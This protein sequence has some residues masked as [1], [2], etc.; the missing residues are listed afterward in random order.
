MGFADALIMMN[1]RY[2]SDQAS[3]FAKRLMMNIRETAHMTSRDLGKE[4]GYGELVR[5]KRRNASLTTIA[6]T[7]TL[8]ILADCSSGIEPLFAKNFTKTVM[9]N[10]KLD[11]G[12]K[13]QNADESI[14]ITAHEISVEKHIEIQSAFQSYTDNAVS[15]TLNLSNSATIED[16]KKA[17][18]LSYQAGC[19][20]VTIFRDGSRAAPLQD[21]D[22][23]SE[24]E[25]NKCQI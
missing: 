15:K 7:G 5:L 20:G 4:K 8:S 16:V 9:D 22:A 18:L 25:G 3:K 1:M 12:K 2:D 13:Y 24:C 17:F 10:V 23:L 19:K 14:I 11:M 6:P 21:K